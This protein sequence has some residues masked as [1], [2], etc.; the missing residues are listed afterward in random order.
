M[1]RRVVAIGGPPGS[2][3]STAGR[4]VAALLG[5]DYRSAGELFREEA[6]RRGLDLETFGR[7]AEEHPEVDQELDRAMQALARPG[8]L[9]DGRIQ[10]T[11]CRRNR[12]PVHV[13]V[14]TASETERVRRVAA[15]DGQ[16]PEVARRALRVREASERD[17]YLRYY[18][19]DLDRERPDA[20]IDSTSTPA[21]AVAAAIVAH[22]E[23]H[24][25]EGSS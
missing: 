22:I 1:I 11:L 8:S 15:R 12:I 24:D 13:L 6:R 17:R 5:L 3:K 4:R 9:L 16:T 14:V 25:G 23:R 18:G 7:F 21:E 10:G 19:I 20:T 2:G